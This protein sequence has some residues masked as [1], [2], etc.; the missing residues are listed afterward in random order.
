M[1]EGATARRE[2]WTVVC[3]GD[4][5]THGADPATGGRLARSV[6]WPGVLA[7]ELGGAAVVIEEGLNGRTTLWDDPFLDG[8]NGMTY[9]LPCLR[10]HA[11]IEVVVIMLGTNDLKTI[12]GRQAHEIAAG[13]GAL[14]EAALRSGTGPDGGPPAVLL[15][16]PPALGPATDRSELWGFGAARAVA[17]ELPRLYRVAAGVRGAAFLDASVLVAG[18]PADGLHLDAAAHGILGRAVA[19]AVRDLIGGATGSSAR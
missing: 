8:R 14:A 19:G 9:L 5:N 16:A 12:F 13:A 17:A 18:D 10:S 4:S 2:P 7:A 6:R 11:P 1:T 15:V 3:Y